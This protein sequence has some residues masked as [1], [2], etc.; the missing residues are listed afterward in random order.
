VTVDGYRLVKASDPVN[1]TIEADS[2]LDAN[3][4]RLL[5]FE[6]E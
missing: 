5:V 2:P 1:A 3:S 4:L 6:K